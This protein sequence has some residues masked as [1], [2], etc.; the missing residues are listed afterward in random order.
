MMEFLNLIML[1]KKMGARMDKIKKG[2][3]SLTISISLTAFILVLVMATQF[4]TVE[5]TYITG[6]EVMREAELRTELAS[7]KSKYE[8][9]ILKVNETENKIIEYTT[10][11]ENNNNIIN[12][13]QKEL[14]EARAYACYTDLNGEGIVV[15]LEDNDYYQITDTDIMTLI[16]DLKLAGAEAIS[17]NDERIIATTDIENIN[18]RLIRINTEKDESVIQSPYIIRAI[19]DKKYL[20]SSIT[21]K[22]GF[23]DS[24]KSA[25]KSVKYELDN[26]VRIPRYNGNLDF[27]YAKTIKE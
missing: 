15:T 16:K 2:K 22:Y 1:D 8:D 19:G 18:Y 21:L 26:N 27:K 14:D 7:W 11:L 10:E 9:A 4:K 25:G 12:L 5:E 3:I 20:E 6:I 24:M 17:I 13:L 23:M